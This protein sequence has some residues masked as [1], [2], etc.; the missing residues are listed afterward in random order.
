MH[1][2]LRK[3]RHRSRVISFLLFVGCP[4]LVYIVVGAYPINIL[5]VFFFS[6]AYSP[7]EVIYILHDSPCRSYLRNKVAQKNDFEPICI[8]L[9][10][11]PSPRKMMNTST[12]PNAI[13][14][15]GELER[16]AID[17][18]RVLLD[19]SWHQAYNCTYVQGF[20]IC[21]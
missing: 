8:T 1:I 2:R 18:T 10:F 15:K 14:L 5:S 6:C 4:S 17:I 20:Q 19:V 16:S 9:T 13:I 11:R 3:A 21:T 12:A 7:D